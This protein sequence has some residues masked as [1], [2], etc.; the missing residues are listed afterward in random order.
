[1]NERALRYFIA[2]R[3]MLDFQQLSYE[4]K[5]NVLRG[6]QLILDDDGKA[7]AEHFAFMLE[8]AELHQLKFRELLRS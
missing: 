3:A 2:N 6:L 5:M 8:K 1:M 7:Q 4:E